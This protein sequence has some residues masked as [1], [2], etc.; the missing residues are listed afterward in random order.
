MTA[1]LLKQGY[2]YHKLH[3]AFSTP[4]RKVKYSAGLIPLLQ[5]GISEQVF[6]GDSV[7]QF[8]DSL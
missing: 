7:Y 6:Y 1:K 8:K 5:Q 2:Q 3:K 4:I